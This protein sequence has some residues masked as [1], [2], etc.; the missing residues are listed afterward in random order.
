[1]TSQ[2]QTLSKCCFPGSHAHCPRG[3][4][5]L[6]AIREPEASKPLFLPL[7]FVGKP[8]ATA[9]RTARKSYLSYTVNFGCFG[10]LAKQTLQ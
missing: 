8:C 2:T 1:M 3:A 10:L 7:S 5:T 6:A 4:L 9:E